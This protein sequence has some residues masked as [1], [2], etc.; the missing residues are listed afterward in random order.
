[1]I[2]NVA[3]SMG[4]YMNFNSYW[5]FFTLIFLRLGGVVSYA[6]DLTFGT[7]D[8]VYDDVSD[9]FVGVRPYG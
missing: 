3:A 5:N 2:T 7:H 9:W 4:L 1:M 8:D 6:G